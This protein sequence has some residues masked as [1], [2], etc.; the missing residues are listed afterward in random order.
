ML[1]AHSQI[2][3]FLSKCYQPDNHLSI[4]AASLLRY[5]YEKYNGQSIWVPNKDWPQ[6]AVMII[7]NILL[8]YAQFAKLIGPGIRT[9]LLDKLFVGT[10]LGYPAAGQIQNPVRS[11]NG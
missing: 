5:C 2:R 4:V 9:A 8:I 1:A 11:H 6:N 3:I 10:G 7:A